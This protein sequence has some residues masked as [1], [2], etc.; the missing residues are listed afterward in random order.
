MNPKLVTTTE[1]V[2]LAFYVILGISVVMLIGIT[3][4]M[5]WFLWRYNRKREPVPLS[6]NDQN[7]PLEIAWT[8]IP[9]ILVMVMFWYG[10][11]GY[12]SLR[13][14]P[15]NAMPVHAK[16]RMWSWQF[17]YENGKTS[18]K[19]YVPAGRPI[20]VE[21]TSEDVLH[22]FFVPAFRIKRDNVPGMTNYAWFVAEEPGSYDIFCAE[23]CGVAHADMVTTVEA[24]PK[25]E[26]E[27]W[28][29]G[30]GEE[31]DVHPG[32]ALLDQYGCIGCHSLDGS[33]KVGPTFQGIAG[34]ETVVTVNGSE[35]TINVDREYLARAINEPNAEVVKGFPPA[36]PS[37]A[38]QVGEDEMQ[39]M[40]DFLLQESPGVSEK[41]DTTE[42]VESK[43]KATP[44]E[45]A[46]SEEK[47]ESEQDVQAEDTTEGKTGKAPEP[48][49]PETAE[50]E[51]KAEQEPTP[52]GA[53]LL[54]QQGCLGCH[55]T[56][57]SRM[58]GPTFKGIFGT[59]V[60][61]EK[62][63]KKQT[64]VR[65]RNYLRRAIVEPKAEIVVGYP[66]VMPAST[67]LS[68]AEIDAI[69]D[70]LETIE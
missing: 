9:T 44:A 24:L 70:H 54:Q 58:V 11:E 45:E 61:V 38:D 17:I 35:K 62:D 15:D 43:E 33:R 36:M 22:S 51:P 30:K 48:V 52:D 16:A 31:K 67:G 25:K 20:K 2:D 6:Q 14:I 21:L 64:V 69:I 41:A 3:L 47:P 63:G 57:G 66:P 50:T 68:D 26:F 7:I 4:T 18:D 5:L 55:S 56:D 23:Y 1:A 8:V 53:R 27:D 46:E 12:L 32:R 59:E 40:I 34:R 65:D 39:Q 42:E 28:L 37:F 10:W 29:A 19:L 49:E 60:E 13:R